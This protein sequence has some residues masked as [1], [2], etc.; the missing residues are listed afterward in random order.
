ML[1]RL[2]L[3]L[4]AG[5]CPY[6]KSIEQPT[7]APPPAPAPQPVPQPAVVQPTPDPKAEAELAARKAFANPGGMW[8]PQQLGLAL[9]TEALRAMGMQLEGKSFTDPLGDPLGAVVTF[10]GFCTGSFVS[11]EG[12]LITN[13]H[14]AQ[15]A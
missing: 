8:L 4:L 6:A 10:G 3:V 5:C 14:C 7:A 9:H 12:L 1:K 15:A 13:H 11:P 2:A